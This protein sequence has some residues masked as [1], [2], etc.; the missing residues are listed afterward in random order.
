MRKTV[1]TYWTCFS[2]DGSNPDNKQ[3]R[4]PFVFNLNKFL[5]IWTLVLFPVAL[6][7]QARDIPVIS[8]LEV[9]PNG[10]VTISWSNVASDVQ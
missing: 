7:A 6:F 8:C 9:H 3:V 5:V 4:T 2:A 10:G 1:L